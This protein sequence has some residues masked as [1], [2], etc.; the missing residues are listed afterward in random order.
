MDLY[1]KQDRSRKNEQPSDGNSFQKYHDHMFLLSHLKI[2]WEF[3]GLC[4][5]R[6]SLPEDQRTGREGY[7]LQHCNLRSLTAREEKIEPVKTKRA[8]ARFN[9]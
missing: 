2:L 3:L 8:S 1:E 4:M 9:R 5:K 6:S 7:F